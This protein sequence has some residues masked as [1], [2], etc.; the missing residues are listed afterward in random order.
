MHLNRLFFALWPDDAVRAAALEAAR[1]LKV[2]MQPGGHLTRPEMLHV[3]LAFLGNTLSAEQEA[4][5]RE[6]AE[7]VRAAPFTLVLDHAGSFRQDKIPWWLG[8]RETPPALA[9]LHRQLHTLLLRA[10][11]APERE[12]F[13]PHLTVLRDAG[14]RLPTTPVRPI[15]WEV[16]D[17]VL[18]RSRMDLQPVIYEL[19]GHWSLQGSQ[20]ADQLPLWPHQ[21]P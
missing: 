9:A 18:M 16:S 21:D 5:A 1:D 2:R 19:L 13:M 11:I 10:K 6:C 14:Q 3:T 7:Q 20:A 12:R 15:R 8:A 4:A 17:F